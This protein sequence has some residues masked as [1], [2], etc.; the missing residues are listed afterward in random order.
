MVND[1]VETAVPAGA[2]TV[3]ATRVAGGNVRV[4]TTEVEVE[5][6]VPAVTVALDGLQATE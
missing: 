6:A 4:A 2:V 3:Q 5:E 1:G